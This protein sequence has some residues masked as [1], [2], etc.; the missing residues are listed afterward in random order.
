MIDPRFLFLNYERRLG[1]HNWH[2]DPCSARDCDQDLLRLR[3]GCRERAECEHL[4]GLPWAARCV[5]CTERKSYRARRKSGFGIGV[6]DTGDF[7]IRSE[8]LFLSGPAKGLSDLAVRS[9]FLG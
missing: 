7:N 2:G 9:A 6:G 4:P 3:R 5:A 1:S 8:E